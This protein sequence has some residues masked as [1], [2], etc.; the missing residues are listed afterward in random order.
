MADVNRSRLARIASEAPEAA[1]QK[2]ASGTREVAKASVDSLLLDYLNRPTSPGM[3]AVHVTTMA[4]PAPPSFS[5]SPTAPPGGLQIRPPHGA[6][7]LTTPPSTLRTPLAKLPMGAPP[8]A[9]RAGAEPEIDRYEDERPTGRWETTPPSDPRTLVRDRGVLVRLDG[10]AGGEVL[11]LTRAPT[12]LGRS[13][14]AQVHISEP[15]VSREHARVLYEYGAYFIED[16]KSQNG[17][18]VAGRKIQR[19]ELRDGDLIQLGQRATYRFA[20]MDETQERVM[21]R[22]YESSMKDPLTG[23]DNRRLLDARLVEEVAFARRHATALSI[24]LFDIDFFKNVN[25]RYG[26]PG[27]DEVLKAV[28]SVIRGELRTEDVFARYGGE[29][30]AVVL[31]D[32]NLKD[33]AMVAERIRDRVSKT[34]IP[35]SGINVVVTISGGCASL[36]CL[37]PLDDGGT[38]E[39]VEAADQRLYVAKREGRNRVF[40]RNLS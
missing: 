7:P 12:V 23:A 26:H 30:F 28:A 37:P 11:S 10:D 31:R 9:P 39:L 3:P 22:L 27:G 25:D 13:A 36:A 15:S 8:M 17:T 6:P 16:G 2:P 14:R 32:T 21:R 34:V 35:L 5:T 24:I 1:S 38:V 29:E 20:L 33:A 18:F 40:S 19:S 4:D